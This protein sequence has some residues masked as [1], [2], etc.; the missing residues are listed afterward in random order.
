MCKF[1]NIKFFNDLCFFIITTVILSF[2]NVMCG[3]TP[4]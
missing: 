1:F 3:N 2:L 4:I